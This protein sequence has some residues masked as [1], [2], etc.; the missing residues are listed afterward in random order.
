MIAICLGIYLFIGLVF[1]CSLAFIAG[2]PVP[3]QVDFH[4]AHDEV[5]S[6]F[7]QTEPPLRHAA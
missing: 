3:N 2:R 5:S 6:D 1:I 7:E 4:P